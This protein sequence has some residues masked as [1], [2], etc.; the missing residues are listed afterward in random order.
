MGRICQFI[1]DVIYRKLQAINLRNCSL[2]IQQVSGF[3]TLRAAFRY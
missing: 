2:P 1:T 3:D